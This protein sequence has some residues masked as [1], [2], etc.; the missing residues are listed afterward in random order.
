MENELK[1]HEWRSNSFKY[2]SK[3]LK[4]QTSFPVCFHKETARGDKNCKSAQRELRW[5]HC[6]PDTEPWCWCI[7]PGKL[8]RVSLC[9]Q[10]EGQAARSEGRQDGS[11]VVPASLPST[12]TGSVRRV[13]EDQLQLLLA[14]LKQS[15]STGLF[16]G[17]PQECSALAYI[18]SNTEDLQGKSRVHALN[19]S[20]A[21][22][23]S[24]RECTGEQRRPPSKPQQSYTRQELYRTTEHTPALRKNGKIQIQR[25]LFQCLWLLLN[26]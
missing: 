17:M 4:C 2:T 10:W 11:L 9:R 23:I 1:K 26:K 19:C 16:K 3:I 5:S 13:P 24:Y 21:N 14:P 25:T 22:W 8:L 20:T 15:F 7:C 6:S 18:T 12:Y